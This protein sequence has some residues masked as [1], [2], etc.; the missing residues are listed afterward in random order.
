MSRAEGPTQCQ[1]PQKK[2]QNNEKGVQ[3]MRQDAHEQLKIQS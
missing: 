2:G 1:D 3:H